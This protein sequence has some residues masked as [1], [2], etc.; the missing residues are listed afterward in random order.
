MENFIATYTVIIID[1]KVRFV[2]DIGSFKKQW[3]QYISRY[4]RKI[5]KS[6]KIQSQPNCRLDK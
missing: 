5:E 6:I 1:T 4:D 3:R 2:V